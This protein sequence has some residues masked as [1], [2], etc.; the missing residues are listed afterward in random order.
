MV[1]TRNVGSFTDFSPSSAF[2]SRPLQ[3]YPTP[4]PEPLSISVP[5]PHFFPATTHLCLPSCL[6]LKLSPRNIRV[7]FLKHECG[8][9][10][11][12]Y[13]STVLDALQTA[14]LVSPSKSAPWEVPV[15]AQ[16]QQAQLIS[17]RMPAGSPTSLSGLR[18]QCCCELGC[19][20]QMFLGSGVA[21]VQ[22]GSYNSN[23]TPA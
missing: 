20:S 21:V 17:K 10:T 15:V 14:W 9:V 7:I 5:A 13:A 19:K 8:H 23:L 22:A 4:P 2:S 11:A 18:I 1:Q 12:Q 3:Q 16:R 6:A